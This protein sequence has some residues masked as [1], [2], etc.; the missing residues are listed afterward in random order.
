MMNRVI[1]IGMLVALLAAVGACTREK[2]DA[3]STSP[4]SSKTGSDRLDPEDP[5]AGMN[6]SRPDSMK[7]VKPDPAPGKAASSY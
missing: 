6:T 7:D 3:A 2:P 4:A 5:K 1:C